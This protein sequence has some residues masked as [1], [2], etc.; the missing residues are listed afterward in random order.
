MLTVVWTTVNILV[1]PE[2]PEP[3]GRRAPNMTQSTKQIENLVAQAEIRDVLLRYCRAADRCDAG[4]LAE[5]YHPDAT[6]DHDGTVGSAA[7]FRAAVMPRLRESWD[8][9]Q[10][11]LGGSVI[12]VEGDVAHSEAYF[13]AYHI[14]RPDERGRVEMWELGA[15][16]VDRFERRD[17]T[18]RIAHRV[19]VRDWEDVREIRKGSGRRFT[20]QRRD[21]WDPC[22]LRTVA[23]AAR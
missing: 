14:R 23:G 20:E 3:N 15:R 16:Y 9:T 8:R 18:W 22:Y 7:R 11:V 21:R 12:E 1:D 13:V 10:H 17:G 2:A 4:L 6:E 19:L 5:L